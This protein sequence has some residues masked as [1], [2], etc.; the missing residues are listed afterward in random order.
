MTVVIF[1]TPHYHYYP[2]ASTES[3]SIVSLDL[4]NKFPFVNRV[5]D[6]MTHFVVDG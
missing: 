6:F 2:K 4:N 1:F 3:L 5:D